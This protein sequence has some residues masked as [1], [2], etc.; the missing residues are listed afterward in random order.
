MSRL[1]DCVLQY[2]SFMDDLSIIK[3]FIIENELEEEAVKMLAEL[4]EIKIHSLKQNMY[5]LK[6]NV[7]M[8]SMNSYRDYYEKDFADLLQQASFFVGMGEDIMQST[9]W[10]KLKEEVPKHKLQKGLLWND[11][12]EILTKN[13][14][15]F[16]GEE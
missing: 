7:A 4:S 8:L 15:K 9:I 12:H 3:Q 6:G 1:R 10:Q 2:D 16:K 13:G 11:L 14:I 5:V